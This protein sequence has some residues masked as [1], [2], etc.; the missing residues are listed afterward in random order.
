MLK[1]S[2]RDLMKAVLTDAPFDEPGWIF[3]R[4]FDGIRCLAVKHGGEV[5]LLSRNDL[6]L[7]ERFPT[8]AAAVEALDA[9]DF[10]LDGEVVAVRGGFA[11]LAHTGGR[12]YF[13]F[14]A[15]ELGGEDV[16]E[17]PLAERKQ[18]LRALG[19]SAPLHASEPLKGNGLTLFKRACRNGWEGLIAKRADS[20]YIA[21]RSRDWLKVK[22]GKEQEFVIGGFT[23]PRGSRTG[24]G[25][26]L[27]GHYRDGALVYAGK[28]GTGFTQGFLD[29][30]AP[31]LQELRQ[32]SSPFDEGD[33]P[34]L[35]VTWVRPELVA[36]VAFSE[37]TAD[38]RL[39][40]PRFLGLRDDKSPEEVV[41]EDA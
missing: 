4:K 10:A 24:F 32:E 13:V 15:L 5:R 7:R 14:D 23:E 9:D 36:Q 41:R 11:G 22:C 29:E 38:G 33:P 37:W 19:L 27:L 21:R 17:L 18:R 6:D 34:H 39:R 1:L 31:R 25:A 3:E 35:R 26:L 28:V 40:H 8:I 20:P 16:R 12:A 2:G 30:L